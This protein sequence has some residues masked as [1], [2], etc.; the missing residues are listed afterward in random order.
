MTPTAGTVIQT[1]QRQ[2]QQHQQQQQQELIYQSDIVLRSPLDPRWCCCLLNGGDVVASAQQS[3]GM[4]EQQR[5]L[6][7]LLRPRIEKARNHFY[8]GGSVAPLLL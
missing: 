7:V 2:Y 1:M 3:R 8:G 4:Q 6:L 5:L